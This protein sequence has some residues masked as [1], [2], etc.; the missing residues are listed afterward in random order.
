MQITI[1]PGK[2]KGEIIP[3]VSKSIAQR[4]I[5]CAL[6]SSGKS[7]LRNCYLSDDIIAARDV[8][9]ALGLQC[10]REDDT[11]ILNG[12]LQKQQEKINCKESGLTMR[13]FA[14]IAALL[15][16]EIYLTAEG[17]LQNR[18]MFFLEDIFMKLGV[19]CKTNEGK[20]PLTIKGPLQNG[21][22]IVDGS[23]TSQFISGLMLA[24]PLTKGDS[25]IT[26]ENITSKPY[27]L[28][29]SEIMKLAG[30]YVEWVHDDTIYIKGHQTYQPLDYTIECDWSSAANWLVAAAISGGIVCDKMN[31]LSLQAD[32]Q[33]IEILK[34]CGA[35][36]IIEKNEIKVTRQNL[37]AFE[38]DI[39]HYPDLLPILAV[40][41]A[42]CEGVSVCKNI[43]RLQYKES[44]R[45]QAVLDM[46]HAC[47]IQA[48][49]EQNNLYVWGGSISG[50]HILSQNDHRITMAAT[51]LALNAKAPVF[52]DNCLCVQKSYPTFF[53]DFKALGGKYNI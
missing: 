5:A 28:L 12:G 44:N 4:A 48:S 17:S 31:L 30:V 47:S 13:L 3:P 45:I 6:L 16:N 34:Q 50:G 53:H 11:I 14:P 15:D 26:I 46:L 37:T 51:I 19:S 1:F 39:T 21:N 49:W 27:L 35:M 22:I 7:I 8:A 10:F 25:K 29:T 33:I 9:H 38:T 23:I 43:N 42:N 41:A 36:V 18:P 2:I 52:I 40:L 24:L 32:K 20:P